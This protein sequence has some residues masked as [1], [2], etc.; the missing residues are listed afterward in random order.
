MPILTRETELFP[1][2]LLDRKDIL[3]EEGMG[4]WAVYT[5]SRR[6]KELMRRLEPMGISFYCPMIEK[7]YR[8]PAGRARISYVPMF[9]NYVFVHGD[10]ET[11]H[12]IWTTNCVSQCVTVPDGEKL[13]H[14]LKQIKQLIT[15]GAPVTLEELLQPGTSVRVKSGS[16][17]GQEG[18]IIERR[19][20]RHLLVAV[21]FLQ[22]GVSVEIEDYAV[23]AI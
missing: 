23:E 9:S 17:A 11:R 6:E 1:F 7:K 5:I 19:G 10:E 8:S 13:T 16:L 15:A 12:K 20:K 4:W 2:D 3:S 14:D 18:V 22:Q 21:T